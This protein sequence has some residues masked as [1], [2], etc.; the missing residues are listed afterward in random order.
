MSNPDDEPMHPEIG[1]K[2]GPDAM[3]PYAGKWIAMDD[4]REI[5]ASGATFSEVWKAAKAAG[6]EVPKLMFV[7]SGSYIGANWRR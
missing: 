1:P 4:E 5:R 2:G 3:A 7:I 6:L